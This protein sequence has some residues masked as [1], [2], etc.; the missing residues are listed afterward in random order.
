MFRPR[1]K[2]GYKTVTDLAWRCCPGLTGESCPEH[3]TDHGATPPH[4]EPEPQIPLG[5]LGPGPRP[6]P[7]SRKA[8]R[9]RGESVHGCPPG[10][11][12]F[13][14]LS[15]RVGMGVGVGEELMQTD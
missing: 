9:P 3:L 14:R 5:Q 1:Y 11:V 13:L 4:Q 2:I 10:R 6:S 15:G 7:Y 8:P 12:G